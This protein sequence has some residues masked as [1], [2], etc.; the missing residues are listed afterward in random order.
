[1]NPKRRRLLQA[2]A[3]APLGGAWPL[4]TLWAA[5]PGVELPPLPGPVRAPTLPPLHEQR[6]A[7]NGLRLVT[8]ERSALPL[9]QAS[10]WLPCGPERD[11]P[12]QAG[13]AALSA[14]VATRGV[15]WRGGTL[16]AAGV[17]AAAEQLGSA[18]D[19]QC[20]P[21]ATVFSLTVTPPV[22]PRALALLAAVAAAP[23]L[24]AGELVREREQALD[25]LRL[26]LASPG[27]VAS[28]AARRAHDAAPWSAQA[29]A[30]SL[31]A[32]GPQQVAA[33]VAAH[34]RP[35]HAAL[36]LC[37]DITPPTAQAL[38]QDAFG[39][40]ARPGQAAPTQGT[41][42]APEPPG[43]AQV[44]IHMPEAGQSA[45]ALALP[46][47]PLQAQDA[48]TRATALAANAVLG[49]NYSSR[50]NQVIRIRRGLSYGVSSQLS[51]QAEGCLL[52]AQA[53]TQHATAL[54]VL[55]LMREEVAR[56]ALAPPD[57]AELAARVAPVVGGLA[58]RLETVQGLAGAVTAKLAQGRDPQDLA[59]D[60]PR[61][62]AVT[63]EAVAD[64]ALKHWPASS[65]RGVIAGQAPG[66]TPDTL[67]WSRLDLNARHLGTLPG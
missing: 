52:L 4:G 62:L 10:L 59:L 47:P 5:T 12:G 61:L 49:M 13:L 32:I 2:S 43:P 57:A 25:A 39:A 8:A 45:V 48:T 9:V 41:L 24:R 1:M 38:A 58:R 54:E 29:T 35:D 18:L 22:L 7:A 21:R 33:F 14:T 11:P 34:Y 26:A 36:V 44:W 66:G 56:L 16:G 53:Q 51:M 46:F 6:L 50:M 17:A 40:W 55:G 28:Q 20:S 15:R 23:L 3:L 27:S 31:A 65:T 64:F 63:P 37:G 60:I 30:R 42:A 67:P 19:V